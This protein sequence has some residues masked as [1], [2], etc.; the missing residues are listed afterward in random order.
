[1]S[2]TSVSIPAETLRQ[3]PHPTSKPI[4][5][6]PIP[7]AIATLQDPAL[8]TDASPVPAKGW[9]ERAVTYLE[10]I[11]SRLNEI[12]NLPI[13]KTL[14]SVGEYIE[15]KFE[16]LKPFKEWLETNGE[17]AWYKKLALYLVKLPLRAA[18]NIINWLYKIIREVFCFIAHPLQGLNKIAKWLVELAHAL[19]QPETWSQLGAGIVGISLGH[20]AI[21]NP[22]SIPALIIGGAM[23]ALGL[24][25]SVLKA[26]VE[27]A[28]GKKLEMIKKTL[29]KQAQEIPEAIVTGVLLGMILAGIQKCAEPSSQVQGNPK[30]VKV[31]KN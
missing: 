26:A 19:S 23:T 20:A 17:G 31:K 24:S 16:A 2:V 29:S 25:F 15:K 30:V 7:V 3:P 5:P 22:L 9:H 8:A 21:A 4:V 11:D 6:D 1:M 13:Q 14:D 18:Y 12:P 10:E 27:S 28:Q